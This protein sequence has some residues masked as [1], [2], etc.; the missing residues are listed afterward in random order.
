M[1]VDAAGRVRGVTVIRG[2]ATPGAAQPEGQIHPR[3]ATLAEIH[4]DPNMKTILRALRSPL[5]CLLIILGLLAGAGRMQGQTVYLTF[6]GGNDNGQVTITWSTPIVYTVDTTSVIS[7]LNPIFVFRGIADLQTIFPTQAPVGAGAPTYTST[8][9]G[10]TDGVQTVNRLTAPNS[11][12]SVVSGDLVFFSNTDTAPTILTAGDVITLS[13]GSLSYDGSPTSNSSYSGMLPADG[14]YNTFITDG[15]DTYFSVVAT[16][17]ATAVPEPS[18]YAMIA[19][20]GVLGLAA[21]RRR[22]MAAA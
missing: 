8:G 2:A 9:A 22:R 7:G 20:L 12:N 3:P 19:G 4:P 16:G 6:S 15:A 5:L 11:F 14:Y 1:R 13:A 17:V 21:W 10:S 18:T